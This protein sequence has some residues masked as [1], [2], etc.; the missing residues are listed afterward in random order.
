MMW[1]G[2]MNQFGFMFWML[3]AMYCFVRAW[4]ACRWPAAVALVAAAVFFEYMSLWSYESQILLILLFPVVLMLSRREWRKPAHLIA[5]YSAPAVYFYCTYLRYTH[6]GGHS[7]Q[8]SVLRKSWS[9]ASIAG[10]WAFNIGSSLEFWTWVRPDWRS[11]RGEAYLL[12]ALAALVFAAGWV[13]ILRR[14]RDR[15]RPNPFATSIQECWGLLAGGFAALALSFPV[16]LLLDTSRG[17]WRTQMLSGIGCG[18]VMAA[19]L[20][21]ISWLPLPRIGRMLVVIP[22]GAVIVYSGSV[23]AIEKGGMH[24]W[25]WDQHR[26]AMLE[27][28]K[29]APDIQPNSV[30]VLTNVPKAED[31]FTHNMWFDMA[32]RLV[33][34]GIPVAGVYFFTDGTPGPGNDLTLKGSSWHWDG[35]GFARI[36]SDTSL[37]KTVAIEYQPTGSGKLL[38]ALPSF[39]CSGNCAAQLYRPSAAIITGPVSP[40]TARRYNVPNH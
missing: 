10:D 23:A 12:S 21:L 5:W 13:A 27:I 18:I 39:V 4:D 20:G 38:G 19:V 1:L 22:A 24:R 7:Y 36:V 26:A 14:G 17:L 8:E 40:I 35:N 30:V 28:L 15:E 11:P 16:Y 25:D 6:S 2:Q 32:L 33:Y 34:P 37:E 31:P 9:L 3:L 29:I